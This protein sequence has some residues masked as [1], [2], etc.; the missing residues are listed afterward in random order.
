[1]NVVII[2][3]GDELLNGQTVNTN[4]AF[5]AE[6]LY[7]KA[8]DVKKIIS[9]G[10]NESEII[11]AFEEAERIAD[12][13]LVTGGLG[14]THDDITKNC[15]IKYFDD[16]LVLNETVLEDIR[17]LFKKRGREMAP[18]NELQAWVPSKA[19]IFRNLLGTAPAF[20]LEKNEKLFAFMPGVPFEMVD[21]FQN[22]ILNFL[23]EKKGLTNFYRFTLSLL[24]TGIPE[25]TLF[26]KL[27]DIKELTKGSKLAFLPSQYGVKLRIQVDAKN[28]DEAKNL[29]QEIE[30]KIRSKVGRYIYG[31]NNETLE[32]V[33]ARLLIDRRLKLSVAESCSGG[34]V[35]HRLTNIPGSSSF[36]NRGIIAYSN[37]AKVEILKVEEDLIHKYGAVSYQVA[38]AMASGVKAISGSD[39]GLGITGIMGPTGDSP[40]KPIGLTY[41]GICDK[42]GCVV[43]D[44]KFGDNR[45]RNKERAS[46]AAL[47]MLR[48][49]ILG[50]NYD[51]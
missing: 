14:P 38:E 16:K 13:I 29:L 19:K 5:L 10:D 22:Q 8:F 48:R 6:K 21:L 25:S 47:E 45:L 40:N 3:I 33:V 2:S 18:I 23:I 20:A 11:Q 28:E 35:S 43:K 17:I 46:Q 44:F 39:I 15:A 7:E 37:A 42:N 9:V 51:E 41:I 26:Q 24:T 31:K 12:I 1:M 50:I 34:L 27:G 4:A 49:N 36:F 32:E 30:Q